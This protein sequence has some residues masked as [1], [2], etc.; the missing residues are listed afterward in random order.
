MFVKRDKSNLSG[1]GFERVTKQNCLDFETKTKCFTEKVNSKRN[2]TKGN[3]NK[4]ILRRNEMKFQNMLISNT[5]N[6]YRVQIVLI[7]EQKQKQKHG[8]RK[9][10]IN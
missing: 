5:P 9:N 10:V 6:K 7:S 1:L 3:Q 2:E 8:L 4:A